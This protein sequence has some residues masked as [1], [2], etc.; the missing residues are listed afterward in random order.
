ME[1]DIGFG[2]VVA[3]LALVAAAVFYTAWRGQRQSKIFEE[4]D[5]VSAQV[6]EFT[7]RVVELELKLS[8]YR[9]WNARLRGQVIELGGTPIAPP[10]WLVLGEPIPGF[11][12]GVDGG[13]GVDDGTAAASVT[14]TVTGTDSAL[15]TIYDLIAEH[16]SLDE[17][18]TLAFRV[19]ID[20]GDFGGDTLPTRAHALVMHAARHLMVADLVREARRLRPRVEWPPV[21][22]GNGYQT[23]L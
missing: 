16:F 9:W 23:H 11:D 17:L 22:A 8:G 13:I 3:L 10:V 7:L 14:G 12:I 5:R 2:L 6:N 18:D 1:Q 21:A 20:T 15:V 4:V 19:G